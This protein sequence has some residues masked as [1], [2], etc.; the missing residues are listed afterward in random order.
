MKLLEGKRMLVT[1]GSRGIGVAIVQTAMAEGAEVAFLYHRS[2]D[3]AEKLSGQMEARYPQQ[4]CLAFQ[5]DIANTADMRRR[6]WEDD[7]GTMERGHHD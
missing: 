6:A 4:R 5:C 3:A 7:L 2:G 1:G